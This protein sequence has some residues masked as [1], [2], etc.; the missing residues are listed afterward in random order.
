MHFQFTMKSYVPFKIF[1]RKCPNLMATDYF[2]SKP[3]I[4]VFIWP[5]ILIKHFPQHF[6][7]ET[8]FLFPLLLQQ[9]YH[10]WIHYWRLYLEQIISIKS[11]WYV[12]KF[13]KQTHSNLESKRFPNPIT[14]AFFLS[15]HLNDRDLQSSVQL[16]LK[17]RAC[18]W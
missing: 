1:Y 12:Y 2:L 18:A 13:Y 5:F 10:G 17:G 8:L 7:W 3:L 15:P 9:Y 11:T 14:L 4:I 16:L 6:A